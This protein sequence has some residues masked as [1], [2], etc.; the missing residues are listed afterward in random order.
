MQADG[1]QA[2]MRGNDW[3]I[4]CRELLPVVLLQVLAL[5]L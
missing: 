5:S 1:G 4:L 2:Q 3:N